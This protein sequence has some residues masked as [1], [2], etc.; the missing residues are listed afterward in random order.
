MT[1][2]QAPHLVDR[3]VDALIDRQHPFWK[4]ER[5]A[6]IFNE[7]SNA[8]LNLQSLLLP[9]VGSVGL[10]IV[11][12]PAIGIVTAM[13]LTG[14]VGQWLVLSVLVRRHVAVDM[15]G[16]MSSTSRTRR[17][18]SGAV[19]VGYIASLARA[20]TMGETF[21][22]PDWSTTLSFGGGLLFSLAIASAAYLAVTRTVR[23]KNNEANNK[24]NTED[25]E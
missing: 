1:K 22:R 5:Q 4:D 20:W 15:K 9:I 19:I 10:L 11:G 16:W 24:S 8:A 3:I 7:A 12:R 13:V 18:I 25:S 6:A 21:D 14:S 2:T 23:Q 17:L